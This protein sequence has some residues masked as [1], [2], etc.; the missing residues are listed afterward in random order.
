MGMDMDNLVYTCVF[1]DVD[2]TLLLDILLQ[3]ISSRCQTK[4]NF[5]VLV[6]TQPSFKTKIEKIIECLNFKVYICILDCDSIVEAKSTRLKIFDWPLIHKYKNILY[7]DT[8]IV[9]GENISDIFNYRLDDLLYAQ[10]EGPIESQYL[11]GKLFDFNQIDKNT[12]GFNSG[13]LLFPNSLTIKF[14]FMD[15][16]K[17]IV[18][19]NKQYPL[20]GHVDQQFINYHTI[21]KKLHNMDLLSKYCTNSPSFPVKM[22]NHFA[23]SHG[24]TMNKY[25]CMKEYF[26]KSVV[27]GYVM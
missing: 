22:F 19:Y 24:N 3:S 21:P 18:D 11:G 26:F 5:D 8:D 15:I 13:V 25:K 20:I 16:Y 1:Y 27:K 9:I 17:H 23:G 4:C 2:Y 14:L 10:R 6:F 7:L 12:Q